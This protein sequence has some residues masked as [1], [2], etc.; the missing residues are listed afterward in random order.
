MAIYKKHVRGSKL[1]YSEAVE[2][3]V[4]FGWIDGK[5][6]RL[7]DDR[8]AVRF[9]RRRKGSVWSRS[10]IERVQDMVS[11]GKMTRSGLEAYEERDPVKCHPGEEPDGTVIEMPNELRSE[12]E[13]D[14]EA[15]KAFESLPPSHKKR[16]LGW[17]SS[18]KKE[19]TRRRRAAE[20]ARM[21]KRER[22]SR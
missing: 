9:T 13:A 6:L 1:R 4:C 2:E 16:Y 11:R 17:I 10:N 18:A 8:F 7:D 15:S 12:L 14:D 20:A 21:M 22:R 19:D 3:A 5:T